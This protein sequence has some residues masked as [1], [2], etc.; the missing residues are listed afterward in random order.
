MAKKSLM[1]KST[2]N[3]LM[4][5]LFIVL[6]I[7]TLLVVILPQITL[8]EGAATWQV[9]FLQWFV[10]LKDNLSANYGYYLLLGGAV[11]A[12]YYFLVFR[13]GKK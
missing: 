9:D 10:N 7:F 2:K 13:P 8:A 4:T 12:A 5:A 3:A 1:K 6:A 11:V